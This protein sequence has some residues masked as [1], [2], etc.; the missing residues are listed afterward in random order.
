MS[1]AECAE[2]S[3]KVT[4][5]FLESEFYKN[6][7]VILFYLSAKN[8]VDTFSAISAALSS[9]K[10][11]AVP[12]TDTKTNTLTLS[13]LTGL[14]GLKEGAFGIFE[15]SEPIFCADDDIDTVVVPGIAFDRN[16]ARI[17]YGKGYYD[18]LFD[19]VNG[20]KAAFCY[21]FQLVDNVCA[22]PHDVSMDFIITESEIIDCGK[23]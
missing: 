6:A 7:S 13:Y 5:R 23:I 20:V 9:G 4:E 2:K 10:K 18:R 16:G 22:E 3:A 21:D 8:E 12:I 19:R 15:P 11:V 17:G 1:A 14:D